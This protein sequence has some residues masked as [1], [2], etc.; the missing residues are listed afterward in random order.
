MTA[1]ITCTQ[2]DWQYID[3]WIIYHRNLGVDLF[4]IAF[5]GDSKDFDRLPKY[6]YVRYFDFSVNQDRKDLTGQLEIKS[7]DFYT[8]NASLTHYTLKLQ[9]RIQNILFDNCRYLYPEIHYCVAID[10]DEF[11]DLKEG[12]SITEFLDNVVNVE[13]PAVWLCM[14]FYKDNGFIY[15]DKRSVIDRFKYD[16]NKF[17]KDANSIWYHKMILNLW[18]SEVKQNKHRIIHSHGIN[19]DNWNK[20]IVDTNKISLCHFHLKSLEEFIMCL[21]EQ[22]NRYAC[23]R[24][25]DCILDTYFDFNDYSDEK[26]KAIPELIKKYEIDVDPAIHEKNETWRQKY[27]KLNCT[28]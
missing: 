6:D 22:Y 13:E 20:H 28:L 24:Y 19:F 10:I 21:D 11:I 2:G 18:N 25:K 26:V 12:T 8:S 15:N 17:N 9:Q 27:I 5:N 14:D 4:L 23:T 1:I 3:E 7:L 16:H